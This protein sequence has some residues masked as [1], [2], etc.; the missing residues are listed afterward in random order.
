[1]DSF[2]SQPEW[3]N[4][5]FKGEIL[6]N[7]QA[8]AVEFIACQFSRCVFTESVFNACKFQDCVFQN[9]DLSL[10][11]FKGATFMGCRFEDSH[12]VG[13]DWTE[14]DWDKSKLMKPVDFYRCALNHST[15]VELNLKKI[16]MTH[17]A[18]LDVDFS[19]TNLTQADCTFTDFANSRFAHTNLTG[20]DFTGAKNY[21]IA[22]SLNTLKKTKFSLPEAMQLLY[23]L[24]IILTDDQ[25][26][27]DSREDV[28]GID[29]LGKY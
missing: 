2:N 17:C 15:F 10:A 20:A 6:K 16:I 18:C 8:Q 4:Q 9:C 5:K 3:N 29:N 19:N 22:A 13:I 11:R 7:G 12:L 1:M 26:I 21:A 23:S 24:D 14:T 25:A 28:E 27:G